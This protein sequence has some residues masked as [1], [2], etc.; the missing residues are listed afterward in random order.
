MGKGSYL[1]IAECA[2]SLKTL[3]APEKNTTFVPQVVQLLA[4]GR[5]I[6]LI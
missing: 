3:R 5:E 1:R 4:G 6:Y 2:E